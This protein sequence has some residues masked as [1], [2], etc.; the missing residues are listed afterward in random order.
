MTDDANEIAAELR[1]AAL[2]A[3]GE[4]IRRGSQ[5]HGIAANL[6]E[7]AADLIDRQA[8][9]LAERDAE[10]AR[11]RSIIGDTAWC[12]ACGSV[13]PLDGPPHCDCVEYG[14]PESQ[15]LHVYDAD[16]HGQIA[17]LLAEIARLRAGGWR[18]IAEAP[19]DGTPIVGA[20]TYR[21]QPY[22]PDGVR[23]MGVPGRWQRLG[24]YGGWSNEAPPA[25][26]MPE[27]ALPPPTDTTETPDHG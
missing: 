27:S 19:R 4:S 2:I 12:H 11:L 15:D 5:D 10:I 8:A 1:E 3:S 17:D 16:A 13:V 14:N 6:A 18:P 26:W 22:K 24:E 25:A 23:Q 20:E 7:T 21:Y 9:T